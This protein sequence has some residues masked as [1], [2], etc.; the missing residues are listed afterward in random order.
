[1]TNKQS[2]K[3]RISNIQSIHFL[4][5]LQI[6]ES[7]H[8]YYYLLYCLFS[9]SLSSTLFLADNDNITRIENEAMNENKLRAAVLS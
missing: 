2:K 9:L 8:Y 5:G 1:M 6:M 7:W 3:Q 4:F